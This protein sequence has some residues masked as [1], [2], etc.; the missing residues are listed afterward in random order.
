MTKDMKGLEKLMSEEDGCLA[1]T[2]PKPA[3]H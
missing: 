1:V 3:I 2:R